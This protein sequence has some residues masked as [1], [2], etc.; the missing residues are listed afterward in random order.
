MLGKANSQR[1]MA[2]DSD[3]FV[4]QASKHGGT[5]PTVRIELQGYRL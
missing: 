2:D 4:Q 1:L 3:L 5:A